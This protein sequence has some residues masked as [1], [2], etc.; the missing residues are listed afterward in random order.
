[1]KETLVN[2]HSFRGNFL[3]KP[4]ITKPIKRKLG[5]PKRIL[6]IDIGGTN[7]K[8]LASGHTFPRRFP[9]GRKLTPQQMVAKVKQL[10]KDWKY[11]VVSIGYPG[12]VHRGRVLLE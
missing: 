11:D 4:G 10:T 7:V 9:S 8:F 3:N 1:M 6:V 2:L 5:K 12:V